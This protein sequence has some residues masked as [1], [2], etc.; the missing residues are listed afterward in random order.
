M[1][2]VLAATMWLI[3]SVATANS[4]VEIIGESDDSYLQ[5]E[6]APIQEQVSETMPQFQLSQGL[7]KTNVVRLTNE[8]LPGHE[9][10]WTLD[11]RLE[12]YSD[13]LIVGDSYEDILEQIAR[14]YVIG[15]CIRPN[16]V[17]EM[18]DIKANRF[19]CED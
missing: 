2:Y 19:Y 11:D 12:Q 18:Y 1:K 10:V 9:V 7:L 6:P 16:N 8:F 14:Q 15:A 17:V 3:C 4:F 13:V 5:I